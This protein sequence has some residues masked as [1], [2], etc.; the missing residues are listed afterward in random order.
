MANTNITVTLTAEQVTAALAD[1][2]YLFPEATNTDLRDKLEQ[3]ATYGP[4]VYACIREWRTQ[5]VRQEENDNR[6]AEEA[7]FEGLF[8]PAPAPEPD[9]V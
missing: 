7:A 4:G 2:R 5:R 8:P 6:K 9:P 3:A 1:A